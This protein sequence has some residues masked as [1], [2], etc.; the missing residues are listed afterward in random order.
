MNR[1]CSAISRAR[2]TAAAAMAL[3]GATSAAFAATTTTT[4]FR[5]VIHHERVEPAGVVAPRQVVMHILEINLADPYVDFLT[6]PDNGAA[7]GEFT[8]QTTSQFAQE[9]GTQIAINGD[10]FQFVSY[11]PNG[12]IYR[13]VTNLAAS[14]G[15]L[16]SPWGSNNTRHG[17]INIS[18][19]NVATLVRP[20]S[21]GAGT[22][23]TVPSLT[24]Y[25]AIGGNDRMINN[26]NILTTDTTIHPRTVMGYK[27]TTLYLFTVDGRQP[28]W[29]EGM[30]LVEIANLLK[31]EYGV[32]HALNL[33]GG[34]STTLV[35]ADPTLRVVNRP[36][37]GTERYNVNNFGVFAANWPAWKT[38]ANGTWSSSANW[39][40]FVPNGV[41]DQV[42]FGA[43]ITQARTITLDMAATVGEL[44]FEGIRNYTI[45]GTQTLTLDDSLGNAKIDVL[46][47]ATH[48]IS[49]PVR[50][51]DVTDFAVSG[52]ATL[53]LLG[54]LSNS[55]GKVIY[56]HGAGTLRIGGTQTYGVNGVINV[57]G[58]VVRLDS[59]AAGGG[60]ANLGL[61]LNGG[62]ADIRSAQSLAY[63][64]INN[65]ATA[66]VLA[67]GDKAIKTRSLAIA[68]GAALNVA[69]ND[70]IVDYSAASAIGSWNG[71]TY[72]GVT[73]L[74]ARGR[75]DGWTGAGLTSSSAASSGALTALAVA[76]ASQVLGLSGT[77]T[78][79]WS[80]QVVDATSVLVK[81]TYDGDATLDGSINIDD[82][83][84]IDANVASSG[85]VFGYASGD[86]NLDGK[87]NVDDYGIIDGNV[88]RQGA[89]I[90]S[91]GGPADVGELSRAVPEPASL[92]L[93]VAG[94]AALSRHRRHRAISH[95][96]DHGNGCSR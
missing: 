9:H 96:P 56:K 52:T 83:G 40:T 44:T 5:G 4:P 84:R 80:G 7:P 41:G 61:V 78:A 55:S 38:N 32:T 35:M 90:H 62:N 72:T 60:G 79:F 17:A 15:Q 89:A 94:W 46:D 10:Y 75:G 76:E 53:S 26:G 20:P 1:T 70:V 19:S 87:I 33:D 86:F 67:G 77:Q 37:D 65:T 82:Y 2:L 18:A 3:A 91:A 30:T 66:T 47:N 24:P 27:G 54:G 42:K 92:T 23:V 73:G 81:Y 39:T 11:G 12:E 57:L 64:N 71:S 49:T 29:S 43:A 36:S 16:I 88:N 58:G 31:N 25:N 28:G 95:P 59:N 34:G 14:N 22:Y 85:S 50:V 13:T 74:V 51:N 21:D 63:L 48:T 69:D 45:T 8:A 68:S 6:T 93:L